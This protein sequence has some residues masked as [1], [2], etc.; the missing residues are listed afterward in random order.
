[1]KYQQTDI[2]PSFGNEPFFILDPEGSIQ[3]A[4]GAADKLL[5]LSSVEDLHTAKFKDLFTNPAEADKM[6]RVVLTKGYV[7]HVPLSFLG[8]TA[9]TTVFIDA[10]CDIDNPDTTKK[11]FV[12]AVIAERTEKSNA[13][14]ALL[15]SIVNSSN[16]AII[17]KTLD[18]I[19]TSWNKAA[20]KI[21][22]YTASEITG[23]P[24]SLLIS[25]NRRNEETEIIEKIRQGKVIEHY[26]TERIKKDGTTIQVSLTISPIRNHL[27][28][29]TGASKISRDITERKRT[30]EDLHK[31]LKEIGDYKYALEESSIVAITDQ[32]GI[33][34]HVNDNFCKISKYTADELIGQDHR[35]INSG[36]H[37]KEFIKKLWVT[38]AN[39][40][41]WKG[42]LKNKAK[43]GTIYW[44]D[45]T[46]VPF[47][48]EKGKPYQYVAIR[49]DI[50]ERKKV[51]EDL[52]SSNR[53]LEERIIERT[54][55]LKKSNEELDAF[56]YS[57]SHDLRAPLRGI[58]AFG[59]ILEEEY[60]NKLDNEAKRI[61]S[62]IRN[63]TLKM[64]ALI[65]D[66]L[67]FSRMGK[68]GITKVP[69]HTQ[70][71]VEELIHEQLHT[72]QDSIEWNI[73]ALPDIEADI[74]MMRQVWI[75]LISN[76]MK[77]SGTR[78]KPVIEI[79]SYAQ[80]NQLVFY[81]KDNGVGFDDE[82]KHKLFKVF[83]RL[84]N[85]DEFEGTGVGLALVE[86]IISRHE[87]KVWAE[88]KEDEGAC[89]YF[90]LPV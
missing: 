89:F 43:D 54:T 16:D 77:Y 40:N 13:E 29:I 35:I 86:K 81:I 66:L 22:G 14:M 24:I 46:I 19:I 59:S 8:N 52:A 84:H 76:A 15:A 88:G 12:M 83:Q 38:I 56:S 58:V 69:I 67:A 47:L 23:K 28:T 75:N 31:S 80:D 26:E 51:E 90:A 79:G 20:E 34:K 36:Y 30:E 2:I 78:E 50:T 17:S 3:S 68:Q 5:C 61:I 60:G 11:I 63:S 82:F 6:L 44:V 74:N 33:I 64:G 57:V 1:M 42:E 48:D 72:A 41:I 62:I 87:G 73:R 37:P 27:G 85:A 18:G 71:M 32:K 49:A 45:T 39:G 55:Q 70:S 7:E 9:A 4:N 10:F 65:D 21:F 53:R 25:A